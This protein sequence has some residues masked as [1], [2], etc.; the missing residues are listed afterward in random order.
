MELTG[1]QL[2]Q[3]RKILASVSFLEK[4]S[5]AELDALVNAMHTRPYRGG[6]E[7]HPAGR[8]RC[9]TPESAS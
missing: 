7:D 3:L 8:A 5:V 1:E 6:G 2:P 4:L 9:L